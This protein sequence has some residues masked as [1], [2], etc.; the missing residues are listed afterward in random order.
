MLKTL[1]KILS[2][3]AAENK[4]SLIIQKKNIIVGKYSL[5]ITE[6]IMDILNKEIKS[7]NLS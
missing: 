5:D 7:I 2:T 1:N 4:I 6:V 3:Y